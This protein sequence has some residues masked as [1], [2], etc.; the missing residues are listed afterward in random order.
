MPIDPPASSQQFSPHAPYT[1]EFENTTCHPQRSSI[2]VAGS[3]TASLDNPMLCNLLLSCVRNGTPHG[4]NEIV[5]HDSMQIDPLARSQQFSP[6][7]SHTVAIENTTFGLHHPPLVSPPRV[8]NHQFSRPHDHHLHRSPPV[9]HLQHE[10]KVEDGQILPLHKVPKETELVHK[11]YHSFPTKMVAMSAMS[12]TTSLL[13]IGYDD[14]RGRI[15]PTIFPSNSTLF[16]AFAIFT[17]LA[18]ASA[19]AEMKLK[20]HYPKIGKL[21][22]EMA[23][24]FGEYN[25]CFH[26][27]GYASCGCFKMGS[28]GL[29]DSSNHGLSH[30]LV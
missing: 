11:K 21:M 22:R 7:V 9:H 15:I 8:S 14:H 24:F 23:I 16:D 5:S 26:C 1:V 13:S 18:F 4:T 27:L 17:L 20:G 29:T 10:S 6:D 28:L 3:I 2:S 12:A 30:A 19:I 25:I